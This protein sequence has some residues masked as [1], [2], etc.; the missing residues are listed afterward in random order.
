MPWT[1]VV[2]QVEN[3]E[4]EPEGLRCKVPDDET[5]EPGERGRSDLVG[6]EGKFDRKDGAPP[7]FAIDIE[8]SAHPMDEFA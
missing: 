2:G 8:A 4:R 3:G 5:A 1:M 7:D 6:D